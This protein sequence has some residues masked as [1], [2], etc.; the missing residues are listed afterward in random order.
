MSETIAGA[1][2]SLS[3][4][5]W[6]PF[7]SSLASPCQVSPCHPVEQNVETKQ[8]GLSVSSIVYAVDNLLVQMNLTPLP[9]VVAGN[10]A[11]NGSTEIHNRVQEDDGDDDAFNT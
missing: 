3:H 6:S 10:E 5:S 1:E 8:R 9:S 11:C 7:G 2:T 4:S